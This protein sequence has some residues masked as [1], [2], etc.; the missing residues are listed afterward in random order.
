M[1]ARGFFIFW[2]EKDEVNTLRRRML[3]GTKCGVTLL[4]VLRA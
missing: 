2:S 4:G 3:S 1:V